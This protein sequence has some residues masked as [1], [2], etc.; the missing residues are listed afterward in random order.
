MG[1]IMGYRRG[2]ANLPV[3]KRLYPSVRKKIAK[4]LWPGGRKIVTSRGARFEVDHRDFVDRQIAFYG[5]YEDD[6]LDYLLEAMKPG[7]DLF[8]DIG[9]NIGL[10]SV[11][12]GRAGYARQILALEPDARSILRLTHNLELNGLEGNVEII[13]Y[14]ASGQVGLVP[15]RFMPA[16][17]TGQS[18]ADP[19]G[20]D[21]VKS[22]TI[23]SLG[24]ACRTI[25]AK[26]DVE[27]HEP[28]VLAGMWETIHNNRVFLQVESFGALTIEGLRRLHS[29]GDDHYFANFDPKEP[30]RKWI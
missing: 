1:E 10:Y 28:A 5:G 23:D 25:F 16:T 30:D 8:L 2:I 9:A 6:Q 3:V 7:C 29:I 13:D 22:I 19:G 27:G 12:V 21:M 11:H 18:R 14:A 20:P 15:F 26:I 24:F 4:A 17:S